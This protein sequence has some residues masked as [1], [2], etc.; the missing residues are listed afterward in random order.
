MAKQCPECHTVAEDAAPYCDACGCQFSKHAAKH[1]TK[2][3]G[4][5]YIS[6]FFV[7]AVVAILL[8]FLRA[9]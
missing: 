4:W 2:A 6:A 9:C 3:S 7:I 1:V 8:K 5:K